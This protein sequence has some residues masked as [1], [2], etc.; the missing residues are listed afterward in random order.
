M[1]KRQ[2]IVILFILAVLFICVPWISNS[3]A[4]SVTSKD[5]IENAKALNGKTI[6]YKGE[7]V[8][9]ILKQGKY[10]WANLNDGDNAIGVW[11]ENSMLSAVKFIGNYTQKG[12]VLEVQGVFHRACSLHGGDLDIHA[13]SIRIVETGRY[14]EEKINAM[15]LNLSIIFFMLLIAVIILFKKRI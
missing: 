5:I 3:F 13:D 1:M 10:S 11:C 7:L 14:V 8:T 6:T 9:A 2:V 12:D 4:G 15:R